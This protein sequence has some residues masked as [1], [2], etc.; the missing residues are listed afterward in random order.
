MTLSQFSS[1][2]KNQKQHIVLSTGLFVTERTDG[3]F[4]IMLY[5]V[6][7]FYVEVYFFNLYNKAALLKGFDDVQYLEPYLSTIDLS[8]LLQE[9]FS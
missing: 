1:S 7:H 9:V 2:S 8:G 4:R 5:Q 6:E 3:P